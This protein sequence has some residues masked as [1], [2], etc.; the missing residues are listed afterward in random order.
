MVRDTG[1]VSEM[2]N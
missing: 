1:V 2:L